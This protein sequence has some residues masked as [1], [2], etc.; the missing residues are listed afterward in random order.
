MTRE[1]RLVPFFFFAAVF[2]C[3][4]AKVQWSAGGNLFLA[5]LTAGGFLLF[6]GLDRLGR[7]SRPGA[8]HGR[9]AA[10]VPRRPSCSST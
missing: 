3:T 6:Y 7:G 1:S 2:T 5:D 9:G 8:A 4:F 10:R